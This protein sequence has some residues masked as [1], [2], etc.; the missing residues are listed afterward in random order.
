V[1][2]GKGVTWQWLVGVTMATAQVV[3]IKKEKEGGWCSLQCDV[4]TYPTVDG[5]NGMHHCHLDNMA[6][7]KGTVEV[8]C[9]LL[10]VPSTWQA[11]IVAVVVGVWVCQGGCGQL[12][13]V[14]GGGSHRQC[15]EAAAVWEV[16]VEDV[17]HC[18]HVGVVAE[19]PARE[20]A[21]NVWA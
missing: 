12:M 11:L 2:E 4:V 8:P 3:A 21:V 15:G 13:T 9:C 14:V 17:A 6:H 16:V 5:N 18:G 20:V 19:P 7:P 10:H 1:A